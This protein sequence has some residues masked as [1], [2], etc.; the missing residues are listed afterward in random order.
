[1]P[2][3]TIYLYLKAYLSGLNKGSAIKYKSK[4]ADID[5]DKFDELSD[6]SVSDD[7]RLKQ[8]AESPGSKFLKKKPQAAAETNYVKKNTGR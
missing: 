6:K 3:L 8:V 2:D 7:D 5:W 4:Q 1:M